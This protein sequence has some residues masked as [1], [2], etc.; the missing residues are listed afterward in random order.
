MHKM[1]IDLCGIQVNK[2]LH[3]KI[4]MLVGNWS[5]REIFKPSKRISKPLVIA[6]IE[7]CIQNIV[8]ALDVMSWLNRDHHG[9]LIKKIYPFLSVT[10]ILQKIL[11]NKSV[12]TRTLIEI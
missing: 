1:L 11:A 3:F 6:K 8:H 4:F 9:M 5:F 7:I 12:P 10:V 2:G